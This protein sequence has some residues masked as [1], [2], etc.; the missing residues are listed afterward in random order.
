MTDPDDDL[1]AL[2][3]RS[4]DRL[5]TGDADAALV[6]VTARSRVRRRRRAAART[7]AVVAA[8]AAVAAVWLMVR[9]PGGSEV[10]TVDSP[11]TPPT[12]ATS[13]PTTAPSTTAPATTIPEPSTS[14]ALAPIGSAPGAGSS[15]TAP[16]TAAAPTTAVVPTAP[17]SSGPVPYR[18]VGG[19]V[20]VRV[21]AGALVL[22]NAAPTTGYV[23][24]EQRTTPDEIEVR[25][26]G[27]NSGTRI[28]VRLDHGQ[29]TGEVQESGSGTSGSGSSGSG[30]SGS[31]GPGT[32][33]SGSSGSGS[34]GSGSDSSGSG[35]SGSGSSGG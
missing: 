7:G 26:A 4:V 33:G 28:R 10:H 25:F 30:T 2:L 8:V 14:A 20:T 11:T 24:S 12:V 18:G 22:V 9:P 16:T 5:P 3:G 6:A 31:S 21:D 13:A 23:I 32:S 17:P 34:S 19:V 29:V 35:S 27:A 15:P 1:A